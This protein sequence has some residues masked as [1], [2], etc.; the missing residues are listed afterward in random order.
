VRAILFARRLFLRA[1][2]YRRVRVHGICVHGLR[3]LSLGACLALA[4]GN[5][6]IVEIG[7]VVFPAAIVSGYV[8]NVLAHSL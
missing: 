2:G 8:A 1:C 5:G 6:I 3:F 4:F 7:G